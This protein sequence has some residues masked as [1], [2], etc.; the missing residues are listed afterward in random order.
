MGFVVY[1]RTVA[2]VE[3]LPPL[4]ELA[5]KA[6]RVPWWGTFKFGA[7]VTLDRQLTKVIEQLP[8]LVLGWLSAS[9]RP[10]GYFHL[11]RNIV[12]N[13]GLLLLGVSRNLL[14]FF[15]ELKGKRHFVRMRRDYRR[16][17]VIGGAGAIA[18]AAVCV[19]LLP[20]VIGFVYGA[21]WV[22]AAAAVAYALL[23]KL[24][25]EGFGIGLGAFVMVT[26]RVWWLARLKLVSLPLGVGA[27]IGAAL[28]GRARWA[29]PLVGVAFGAAVAYAAWWVALSL[30]QLV[31]SF[32][33]L[34]ALV[35]QDA[36][37]DVDQ[38]KPDS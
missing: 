27:L 9:P 16:A 10:A 24:V 15:A 25:A 30:I 11:G 23:A 26:D 33:V 29:D 19:P 37:A 38:S 31:D 21:D 32:R 17:V 36:G 8:V 6:V 2:G 22:A 14:P 34:N 3:G 18:M 12:R 1:A 5:G 13:L 35:A 20:A 28:L 4:G 7:R